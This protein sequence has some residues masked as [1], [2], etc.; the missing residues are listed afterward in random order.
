MAF[1]VLLIELVARSV[2]EIAV[3]LFKQGPLRPTTDHLMSWRPSPDFQ[4]DYRDG[5]SPT[6]FRHPWYRN[7]EQYPSGIADGVGY[8]A[9][10]HILGGVVLFDRRKP[11]PA[12]DVDVSF[13]LL[14]SV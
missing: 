12:Q 2:H 8:W 13:L 5:T 3:Q 6:W 7:Y 14:P 9:E 10:A 1:Q 4:V 11:G